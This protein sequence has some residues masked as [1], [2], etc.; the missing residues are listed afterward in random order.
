MIDFLYWLGWL[1]AIGLVFLLLKDDHSKA[2]KSE[3]DEAWSDGFQY[4]YETAR[5]QYHL[6]ETWID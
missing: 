1:A 3:L 4:G 6:D 5:R 2:R